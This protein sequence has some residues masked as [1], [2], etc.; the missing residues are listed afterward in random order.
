MQTSANLSAPADDG[1][2]EQVY[3]TN[4]GPVVITTRGKLVF[5][6]ESFPLPL[7]RKLTALILD[8]Q[9]GGAMRMTS[10]S[11]ANRCP[12]RSAVSPQEVRVTFPPSPHPS[13]PISSASSANAAR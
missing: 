9:G 11:A 5:V 1:S 2:V 3:S 10:A 12:S 7:A 6:S 13:P 4:E 8:A